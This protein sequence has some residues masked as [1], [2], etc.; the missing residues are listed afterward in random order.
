MDIPATYQ[1]DRGEIKF[2]L[3]GPIPTASQARTKSDAIFSAA[4]W[5]KRCCLSYITTIQ[6]SMETGL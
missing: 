3:E 1:Y 2:V 6:L 5:W 4:R